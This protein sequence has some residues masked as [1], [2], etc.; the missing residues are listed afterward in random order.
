MARNHLINLPGKP[1]AKEEKQENQRPK[2][3]QITIWQKTTKRPHERLTKIRE[4]QRRIASILFVSNLPAAIVKELG[5]IEVALS[6]QKN[7]NELV[8]AVVG[9]ECTSPMQS[10][11]DEADLLMAKV[12]RIM[13]LQMETILEVRFTGVFIIRLGSGYFVCFQLCQIF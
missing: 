13:R 3:P 5:D 10:R 11:L 6:D 2:F 7:A 4:G 12:R 8:D 1:R 9:E